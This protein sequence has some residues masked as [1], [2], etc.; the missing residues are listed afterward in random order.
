MSSVTVPRVPINRT[1]STLLKPEA[2]ATLGGRNTTRSATTASNVTAHNAT[3]SLD[4]MY[5]SLSLCANEQQKGNQEIR[6]L[7]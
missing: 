4:R 3:M 1:R 2:R 7:R 5:E 6:L